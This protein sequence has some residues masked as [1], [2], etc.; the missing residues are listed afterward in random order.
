MPV[1][2]PTT[3]KCGNFYE[4]VEVRTIG[5]AM[6]RTKKKRPSAERGD[7][8]QRNAPKPAA[9]KSP[10]SGTY[11]VIAY[12]A[13]GFLVS[14]ILHLS[15]FMLVGRNSISA[16]PDYEIQIYRSLWLGFFVLLP[17]LVVAFGCALRRD[18]LTLLF[19]L[20]IICELVSQALGRS[21][22]K[23]TIDA[24]IW[25]T[26]AV[27]RML[28][29]HYSEALLGSYRGR[30]LGAL[31][32]ELVS[33]LRVV[34][35]LTFFAVGTVGLTAGSNLILR[36]F[37]QTLGQGTLWAFLIG[38]F[39]VVLGLYFLLVLPMFRTMVHAR[40]AIQKEDAPV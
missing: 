37:D 10:R 9:S 3:F 15:R 21:L 34:L 26:I 33:M 6:V 27:S 2:R 20:G 35:M 40:E 30:A 36:N 16:L 5:Y 8:L 22:L 29:R 39:Y 19:I 18:N 38:I 24:G 31:H 12:S 32:S 13:V 25:S 1:D 7:N 4:P 23:F 28:A 14:H 11:L 17:V